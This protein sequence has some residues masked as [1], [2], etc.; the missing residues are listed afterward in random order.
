MPQGRFRGVRLA[1]R[2]RYRVNGILHEYLGKA[3]SPD[4]QSTVHVFRR[5]EWRPN[6]PDQFPLTIVLDADIDHTVAPTRDSAE[7]L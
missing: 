2:R 6:T 7:H 5:N 1:M 4:H 3:L